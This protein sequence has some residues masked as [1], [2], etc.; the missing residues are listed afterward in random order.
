MMAESENVHASD[1]WNTKTYDKVISFF[2]YSPLPFLGLT[3]SQIKC[4]EGQL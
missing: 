3:G 2:I 1:N 4:L